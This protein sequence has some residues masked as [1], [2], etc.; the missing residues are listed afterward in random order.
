MPAKPLNGGSMLLEWWLMAVSAIVTGALIPV[1]IRARSIGHDPVHGV[2]KLH[3]VST[4]R[5]GGAVIFVAF[6]GIAGI[7][8]ILGVA[9]MSVAWL[10]ALSALPVVAMGV[11]EDVTRSVRPRYRLLAAL[12]SAAIASAA[13]GGIVPRVDLAVVDRLLVLA[14]VALPLTW[15]MVAGACNAINLIDGANGLAGG[16]AFIMF[17]GIALMAGING[18]AVTLAPALAMMGALAGFL[19]WNYPR[20]RVFLGDAG[21]YFVGFMYAQ[22]SIQLVASNDAI[23]AWYVIMLAGYPIVD[24]LVAM[25]RRGWVRRR[26]LMSPDALHLHSLVFRRVT[27]PLERRREAQAGQHRPLPSSD[28][29]RLRANGKVAP[30]VWLHSALCFALAVVFHDNTP[31]LWFG[32]LVYAALYM[33]R[34]RTLVRFRRGRARRSER[35]IPP[36]T[37]LVNPEP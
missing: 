27:L 12:V 36:E 29:I 30:R 8:Y 19:F 28:E 5:L 25:Y 37:D 24:T 31:A 3:A 4:S 32:L 2:Q 22:L 14:W 20:G 17:G 9:S 1:A 21:A 34:Y 11:W 13:V 7:A 16:T 33:N 6:I 10:L 15:F 23:S 18:D 35:V 26:P